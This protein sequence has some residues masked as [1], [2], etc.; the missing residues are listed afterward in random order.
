[1]VNE[2]R[3]WGV[4]VGVKMKAVSVD[5]LECVGDTEIDALKD[6]NTIPTLLPGAAFFLGMHYQPARAMI[7]GGLPVCLATDYNPGNIENGDYE[8]LIGGAADDTPLRCAIAI[9]G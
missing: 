6:S 9:K 5:H 3:I 7:D 8:L 2:P 1:M 4:E